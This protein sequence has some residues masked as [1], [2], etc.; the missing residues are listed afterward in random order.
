MPTQQLYFEYIQD[1]STGNLIEVRD[2][3]AR[4]QLVYKIEKQIVDSLPAKPTSY[5]DWVTMQKFVYYLPV[6]NFPSSVMPSAEII[7]SVQVELFQNSTCA[8]PFSSVQRLGF[9]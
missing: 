1:P 2:K 3:Y 9:Q 5:S 6:T 7:M 4:E 8:L